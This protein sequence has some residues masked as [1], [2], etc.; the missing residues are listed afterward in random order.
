MSRISQLKKIR[1]YTPALLNDDY[2]TETTLTA[3]ECPI[4][5]KPMLLAPG[6]IQGCH[7]E[8]R[9]EFKRRLKIQKDTQMENIFEGEV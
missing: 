7:R 1:R 6:Q 4:C 5:P 2:K 3:Y 9:K 8:C